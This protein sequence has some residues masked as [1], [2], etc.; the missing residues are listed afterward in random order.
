MSQENLTWFELPHIAPVIHNEVYEEHNRDLLE[1]GKSGL[2]HN[3]AIE[4][5][6]RTIDNMLYQSESDEEDELVMKRASPARY[7]EE[8]PTTNAVVDDPDKDEKSSDIMPLPPPPPP[9]PPSFPCPIFMPIPPLMPSAAVHPYPYMYLPLDQNNY[10]KMAPSFM[11][12]HSFQSTLPHPR[13]LKKPGLS[14]SSVPCIVSCIKSTNGIPPHPSSKFF[15]NLRNVKFGKQK[16][17]SNIS[18]SKARQTKHPTPEHIQ[19]ATAPDNPSK[20]PE[21]VRTTML[22]THNRTFTLFQL[23][24]NMYLCAKEICNCNIH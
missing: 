16:L 11:S 15:Q 19:H 12:V 4:P 20:Q 10:V 14:H 9:P 23:C 22:F 2:L 6:P 3:N 5:R 21:K 24:V 13:T 1:A 17:S 8:H 7:E 18:K